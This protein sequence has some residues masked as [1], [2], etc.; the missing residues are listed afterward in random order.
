MSSVAYEVIQDLNAKVDDR[1]S[2]HTESGDYPSC[3]MGGNSFD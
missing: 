1:G 2:A 3:H